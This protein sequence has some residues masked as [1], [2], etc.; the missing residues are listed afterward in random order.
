MRILITGG[1]G[2]IGYY[3][4]KRLLKEGYDIVVVDN[5]SRSSFLNEVKSLDVKL[6]LADIRDVYALWDVINNIDAII[7]LA[8]L[9]NAEE[10]MRKPLL[11]HEV[12]VQGTLNILYVA[13]KRGVKRMVLASSAA[14]Y[15]EPKKLPISEDHP[16]NPLSVYG[17]TKVQGEVYFRLFSNI[18]NFSAIILR[19]FNVYGPGQ[20]GEYS[21][22]ITNFI[23]RGL[24]KKPLIIYGDGRQTRDF[25]YVEDVA[26]AVLRSLEMKGFNIFN[27]GT[28]HPYS[29]LEL[30]ELISNIL[31]YKL[32]K[33]FKEERPG[34]ITHSYADISLAREKLGF[35]PTTS[36]E[37]GLKKTIEWFKKKSYKAFK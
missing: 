9:I 26:N 22:V 31:G 13:S 28:G 14:V 2:F 1:A 17:A 6:V 36:L 4:T 33:V 24:G 5:G 27:I 20:K 34:D 21:G 10:S 16:L 37:E 15:G 12:N 29:V 11:Y 18:Y 19:F 8:A 32:D 7:H 30:A 23:R 3:V 35:K 25:V